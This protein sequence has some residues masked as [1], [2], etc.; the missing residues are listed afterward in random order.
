MATK[1]SPQRLEDLCKEFIGVEGID[2]YK[3]PD[4]TKQYKPETYGEYSLI[5]FLLLRDKDPKSLSTMEYYDPHFVRGA[6]KVTTRYGPTYIIYAIRHA[7]KEYRVFWA[8]KEVKERMDSI[9]IDR[10]ESFCG[11]R[12]I[13][14]RQKINVYGSITFEKNGR[15]ITYLDM[16]I[17]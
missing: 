3:I 9:S 7:T 14:F 2:T 12:I 15:E 13:P 5:G 10:Y 11:I 16:F 6:R 17:K 4:I 8:N 1:I